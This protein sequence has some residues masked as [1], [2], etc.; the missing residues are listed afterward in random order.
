MAD[1][2][3]KASVISQSDNNGQLDTIADWVTGGINGGVSFMYVSLCALLEL[4]EMSAD[5]FKEF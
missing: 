5:E 1:A 3:R 4:D 2:R